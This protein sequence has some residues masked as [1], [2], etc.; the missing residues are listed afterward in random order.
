VRGNPQRSSE[1]F[2][3]TEVWRVDCTIRA[4]RTAVD[5]VAQLEKNVAVDQTQYRN[6]SAEVHIESFVFVAPLIDAATQT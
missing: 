5:S 2:K 4:Y 3:F 1:Y 6:A